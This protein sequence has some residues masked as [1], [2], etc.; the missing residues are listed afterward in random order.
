MTLDELFI[1]IERSNVVHSSVL[2]SLRA[3][4]AG[5]ESPRDFVEKCVKGGYITRWQ[6]DRFLEG[7]HRG[8]T[9]DEFVILQLWCEF[10]RAQ[11]LGRSTR[12]AEVRHIL[13][14]DYALIEIDLSSPILS[15]KLLPWV[16]A[17]DGARDRQEGS[18]R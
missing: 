14:G 8:F 6:G 2:D 13:S 4:L 16:R 9:V 11:N 15:W 18:D 3:N 5:Q 1:V 7:K 10:P 17:T 12:L